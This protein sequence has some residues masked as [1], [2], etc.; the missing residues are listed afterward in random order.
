MDNWINLIPIIILAVACLFIILT[1]DWKRILIG[2]AVIY[3]SAFAIIVQFWSFSFS[4]VKL[5][6]GLMALVV[7]GISINKHY[8]L[9]QQKAKSELI[10][11]LIAL[12]LIFLIMIF[13]VYRI[14]NYLSISLEIVLASLLIIGF[15]VYQLG[16][17]HEVHRVVL[18]IL[19]IFFGFDLIFSS[20]ESSLLIN[21]LL[22]LISLLVALIGG[23]LIVNEF[24]GM[25]E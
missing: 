12:C 6:T 23:Y 17:T 2:Y 18:A 3:L 24:E 15:G 19:I 8:E 5:L 4:L 10:F 16:I 11:G 9:P 22:A 25:D 21:G 20:N 1:E 13:M 14:S 7:L